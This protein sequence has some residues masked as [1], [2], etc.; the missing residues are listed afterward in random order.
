MYMTESKSGGESGRE[1]VFSLG[2]VYQEHMPH[3]SHH[4]EDKRETRR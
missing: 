1:V 2:G 3:I 4:V